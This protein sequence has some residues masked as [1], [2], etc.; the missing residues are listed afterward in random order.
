[1]YGNQFDLYG[2]LQQLNQAI[3]QQ[4]LEIQRLQKSLVLIQ[5]EIKDLKAKPSTTIEKVEYKFD[6]LKI[7][8]LEGTLNIGLNPYNSEQVEDFSV[9]QGKV[10]VPQQSFAPQIQESVRQSILHYLDQEG[11]KKIQ[12]VQQRTG[13]PLNEDYYDFMIQDVKRQLDGRVQYYLEQTT[14]DQWSNEERSAETIEQVI[15]K[16]KLDIDGAFLA[17]VQHLP[18]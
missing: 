18:K 13:T 8:T 17:F 4:Q 5:T 6:Q 3:Q 14:S 2:Y 10:N 16:M 1:M 12:S 11:Y 9:N 15:H 7:E